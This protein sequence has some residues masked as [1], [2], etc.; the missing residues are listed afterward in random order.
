MRTTSSV[1]A[2]L[3]LPTAVKIRVVAALIILLFGALRLPIENALT[4]EHRSAYFH[5]AQLDLDMR[6]RLGQMGFVAALSGFRALIA[7]LLWIQA[8]SAWERTEWGRM[9]LLFDTVTSL[10]PRAVMFWDLASW[11]M[12]WNAS[13]AML[14]DPHQPREALRIK[15]QREYWK[16]G[17]DFLLRGIR[18][19]PERALLY[20]RLGMLYR[21]KFQDHARAQAAYEQAAR[22]PDAP[23]YC[24]RFAAYELSHIP[25]REREAYNR[26]MELYRMG[27]DE[28]LPTLLKRIQ[29]MEE[30]LDVPPNQRIYNPPAAP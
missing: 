29:A 21:D 2:R 6:E 28:H 4:N 7:D 24:K 13:V 12:A 14:E 11:H 17:E 20:D 3:E 22:L 9:K 1:A 18:N 10:Q 19:N 25:G 27:E 26:L 30:K 5:R 15:A 23:S 8:H 16:I